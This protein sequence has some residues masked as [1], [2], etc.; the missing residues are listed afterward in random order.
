MRLR[1]QRYSCRFAEQVLNSKLV[2]KQEIEEI[3]VLTSNTDVASLSRPHFNEILE[4]AFT[5]KGWKSQPSVFG[6][7]GD[8]TA[9]L[10]FLRERIGVEIQFGHS[11]FLGIDLLKFQVASYSSLDKIDVGVYVVTTRDFQKP[12]KKDFGQNW[13]GSLS[14]EKVA[15]YLPH[16]KSAVQV[17]I[18]VLG[19]DV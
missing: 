11:S 16:F 10:D 14:F 17:P 13:R 3:L 9:K 5:A 12:M 6:E 15:R 2:L 19:I 4:V 7:P 8:P 1:L 18:W